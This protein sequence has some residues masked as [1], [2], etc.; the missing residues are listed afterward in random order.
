[1]KDMKLIMENFRRFAEQES[2]TGDDDYMTGG[3]SGAPDEEILQ[4]IEAKEMIEQSLELAVQEIFSALK[5]RDITYLP[6]PVQAN[7]L[8]IGGHMFKSIRDFLKAKKDIKSIDKTISSSGPTWK[9]G[10]K[11]ANNVAKLYKNASKVLA[12][13]IRLAS[14]SALQAV[15]L[16]KLAGKQLNRELKVFD[17]GVK[18]IAA[19]LSADVVIHEVIKE[20]DSYV[21]RNLIESIA[22]MVVDNLPKTHPDFHRFEKFLEQSEKGLEKT[23]FLDKILNRSQEN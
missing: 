9:L 15:K 2:D 20:E 17:R 3:S 12:T 21:A 4:E 7:P 5:D 23:P 22:K 1:M 11:L 10:S 6:D 19:G 14:D 8:R 13:S 16:G 18:I